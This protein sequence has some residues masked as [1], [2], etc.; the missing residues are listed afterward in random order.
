MQRGLAGTGVRFSQWWDEGGERGGAPGGNPP[1]G[2]L[3]T[4]V[5]LPGGPLEV[6]HGGLPAGLGLEEGGPQW[7]EWGAPVEQ[8]ELYVVICE[9][10]GAPGLEV[11][12]GS[13]CVGDDVL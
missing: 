2:G 12:A 8:G 4:G 10:G 11:V 7:C 1:G 13:S 3:P 9:V 6:V 5:L